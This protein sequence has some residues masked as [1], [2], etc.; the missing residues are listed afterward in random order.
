MFQ[1]IPPLPAPITQPL[2]R[3]WLQMSPAQQQQ[4]AQHWARLLLQI[5]RP[6]EKEKPRADNHPR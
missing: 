6:A 4:L 3:P 5:Q 2:P 1:P